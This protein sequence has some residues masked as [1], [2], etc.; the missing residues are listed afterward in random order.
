[1]ATVPLGG[2]E[3]QA[4]IDTDGIWRHSYSAWHARDTQHQAGLNTS[5]FFDTGRLRHELKFGFGYTHQ[6]LDSASTWPGDLLVGNGYVVARPE[7]RAC[8]RSTPR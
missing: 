4:D 2:P 8:K 7:S 3:E 6:R 1:M 5:T